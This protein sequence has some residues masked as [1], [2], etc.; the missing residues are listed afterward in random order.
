MLK[1]NG[2]SSRPPVKPD[3]RLQQLSP[4]RQRLVEMLRKLEFG[5][6]CGL[7]IR[8][9]DPVMDPVPRVRFRKK[10]G[11]AAT[12]RPLA[13]DTDFALKREWADFFK[14][15]DEIGDGVI[16]LIEVAHGLPIIHE[17]EGVIQA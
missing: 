5:A 17:Y 1:N 13:D 2:P 10:N 14:S 3:L 6:I 8:A 11:S 4:A 12:L 7:R 9:G 15:L 16:E